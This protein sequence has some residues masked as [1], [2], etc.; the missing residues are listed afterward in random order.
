MKNYL[1][2][3]LGGNR[4]AS[5]SRMYLNLWIVFLASGFWHG[6]S[7]T[8]ILWGAYH[9]SFLVLE[10]LF[11]LDLY[12]RAGTALST[13]VTFFL[14]AMGWVLFRA[15]TIGDAGVFVSRLFS[16]EFTIH[17][18]HIDLQF[19]IV[20][21]LA[22]LF[23]FFTSVR[24]G[25]RIQQNVYAVSRGVPGTVAYLAICGALFIVAIGA[26]AASEF[27]PFIYFRF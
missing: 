22:A 23:S 19:V 2:I 20:F 10:R 16:F 18:N 24:A 8:F 6:A 27:N 17:P 9:G 12:R 25:A 14:I 3:P 21:S 11:L 15:D 5:K 4:V 13:L 7:W 26:L 1:Y